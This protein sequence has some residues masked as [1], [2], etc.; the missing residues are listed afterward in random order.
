MPPLSHRDQRR[1]FDP[2]FHVQRF[3]LEQRV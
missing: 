2:D 1:M 3:F